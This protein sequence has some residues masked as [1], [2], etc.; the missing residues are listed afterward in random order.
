MSIVRIGMCAM[1]DH[2]RLGPYELNANVVPE[3]YV[4]AVERAGALPVMF[5]PS[6]QIEENPDTVL[7]LVDGLLLVGGDDLDPRLYGQVKVKETGSGNSRRDA[8]EMALAQRALKTG[9]PVLGIC[10]GMQ[11]INVACGGTLIQ[12]LDNA[13]EHSGPKGTPFVDH[14]VRLDEGSLAALCAGSVRTHIKSEHHQ[15]VG[16]VGEGLKVTGYSA[17]DGI[18]EAIELD[19]HPFALGVLWHPEQD[20]DSLVIAGFVREVR[21]VANRRARDGAASGIQ[22]VP[23]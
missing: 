9:R 4:Q 14:E 12:H 3:T 16:T 8:S 19:G 21:A 20:P 23:S 11:L 6:E 5:S 18:V 17:D 13:K 2:I 7:D 22:P 10:R 1:T 15:G